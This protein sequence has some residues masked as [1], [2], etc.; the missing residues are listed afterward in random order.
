MLNGFTKGY[1]ISRM[2]HPLTSIHRKPWTTLVSVED[3]INIS[4]KLCWSSLSIRTLC[5]SLTW[6]STNVMFTRCDYKSSRNRLFPQSGFTWDVDLVLD[7]LILYF[8]WCLWKDWMCQHKTIGRCYVKTGLPF[9]TL[10]NV[11]PTKRWH[12]VFAGTLE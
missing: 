4:E 3:Y 2:A 10:H 11:K 9:T 7:Q 1:S 8:L 5:K 6:H 12:I